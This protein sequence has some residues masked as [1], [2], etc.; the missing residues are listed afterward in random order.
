[1]L[2]KTIR[3]LCGFEFG[4]IV[5]LIPLLN[6]F[7]YADVKIVSIALWSKITQYKYYC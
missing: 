7:L 4:H 2:P 3:S 1:M 5:T 6:S